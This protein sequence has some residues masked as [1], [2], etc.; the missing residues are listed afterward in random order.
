MRIFARHAQRNGPR[1]KE[2]GRGTQGAKKKHPKMDKAGDLI[3][4]LE[5]RE[6]RD[7]LSRERT[8]KSINVEP[9]KAYPAEVVRKSKDFEKERGGVAKI[10]TEGWKVSVTADACSFQTGPPPAE[11]KTVMKKPGKSQGHHPKGRR[12]ASSVTWSKR[13][14]GARQLR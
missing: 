11:K 14:G 8:K 10:T 3:G 2:P 9:E 1:K 12:H 13:S 4:D 5:R 7:T 6:T